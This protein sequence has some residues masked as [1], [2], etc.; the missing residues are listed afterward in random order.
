MAGVSAGTVDRVLHNRGSVSKASREKVERV[1]KEIDYQPNMFAIGLAAKKKYFFLCVI[2]YY[3]END[4]WCSIALGIKKAAEELRPFNISIDFLYYKHG[5]EDSYRNVCEEL[6]SMQIDAVLLAPIFEEIT[7]LLAKRLDEKR[8][9]YAFIDHNVLDTNAL[10]YIGQDSCMSGYIAGKILM[11][12]YVKSQEIALF[13]NSDKSHPAE[14]Q[15][16][17]RIKGFFNFLS[18][19]SKQLVV[20]DVIFNKDSQEETRQV[21]DLFFREHPNVKLGIVFNSRAHCIAD[22]L[23]ETGIKLN[24]FIGYDLLKRNV[25]YLKS[26]EIKYLIG[27]RPALQGYCGVKSLCDHL[28]F[29]KEVPSVQFMPI[30]ILMKENIDYYFELE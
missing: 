27:Q 6:N 25:E 23:Q 16:Q 29:K 13:L 26:G 15:V 11:N 19:H 3:V 1:L 12:D 22:Y 28:L 5:E 24:S 20:H 8:I 9:P 10:T 17:R 21:L 7:K 14:I 2:P 18:E 4:Y 30:D